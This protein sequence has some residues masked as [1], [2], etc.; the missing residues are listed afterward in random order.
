MDNIAIIMCTYN[1]EKHIAEQIESIMN[2]TYKDFVKD[3]SSGI[4]MHDWW[5][6]LIAS[7]FGEV[8]YIDESLLKYR[9]HVNNEVGSIDLRKYI[10]INIK[11]MNK[12]RS[13][14]YAIFKQ[15]KVFLNQYL[16][17]EDKVNHLKIISTIE[18][19]SFF[20]RK[21]LFIKINIERPG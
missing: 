18:E 4:R 16:L 11:N 19:Q 21:Y 8:I 20:S 12:Q 3:Y 7:A 9:Q 10:L 1:G 15:A 17:D 14:L 2:N 6:G 5:I 13:L